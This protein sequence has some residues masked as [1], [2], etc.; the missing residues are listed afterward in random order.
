MK[1]ENQQIE[2]FSD[3]ARCGKETRLF[4]RDGALSPAG[5]SRVSPL[6]RRVRPVTARKLFDL[7]N[8]SDPDNSGDELR[9]TEKGGRR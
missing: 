7:L 5:K 3:C 6:S 1:R 4:F 8:V 9:Q 2:K